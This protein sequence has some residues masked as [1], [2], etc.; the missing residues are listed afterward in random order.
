VVPVAR[1]AELLQ[2]LVAGGTHPSD[3]PPP[4]PFLAWESENV[5]SSTSASSPV[6]P[7]RPVALGCPDCHGGM[8]ESISTQ[9]VPHYVC[10][11]GHSWSPESLMAAQH[12]ASEAALYGAAAKLLEEATVLRQLADRRRGEGDGDGASELAAMAGNAA[13]RADRIQAM[14]EAPA[15]SQRG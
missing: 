10:H 6:I 4:G 3:G 14:L 2:E 12:E 9:G 7:G 8:F 5:E 13:S 11:V 15:D 1:I